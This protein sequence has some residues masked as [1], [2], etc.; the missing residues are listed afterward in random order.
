VSARR[1]LLPTPMTAELLDI[2]GELARARQCTLGELVDAAIVDQLPRLVAEVVR[3]RLLLEMGKDPV[4]R[5]LSD[6]VRRETL[7]SSTK[8]AARRLPNGSSSDAST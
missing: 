3:E 4:A 5:V 7:S 6:V 8:L 1:H 2:L